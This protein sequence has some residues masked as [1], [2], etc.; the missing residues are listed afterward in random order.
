MGSV[1]LGRSASGKDQCPT[2]DTT[3]DVD[4]QPEVLV[5]LSAYR[6]DRFEVT[7]ARFRNFVDHWDYAGMPWGAGANI[8]VP[9]TGWELEWN[10]QLPQSRADLVADISSCDGATWTDAPGDGETRPINCVSWYEAFA[11]CAWDGARL[12]T[13]AEWEYAAANGASNDLHPWGPSPPS[14]VLAAYD[15]PAPVVVGSFPAGASASGLFDLAGNVSEWTRDA[16]EPYPSTPATD[17]AFP[18]AQYYDFPVTRGGGFD[19]VAGDLRAA[20][21]VGRLPDVRS[22]SAGMRC[23]RNP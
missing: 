8:N 23:A 2:G 15:C 4:E 17:Y 21:R 22:S 10:A 1:P 20:R 13:E 18:S 7:V 9:F 19:G 5:T 6:L 16:L 14:S 11:F 3:C 12:P